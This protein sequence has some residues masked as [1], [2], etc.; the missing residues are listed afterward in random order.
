MT[1]SGSLSSE[2]AVQMIQKRFQCKNI[3]GPNFWK[4]RPKQIPTRWGNMRRKWL[5]GRSNIKGICKKVMVVCPR[6]PNSGLRKIARVK[7]RNKRVVMVYIPGIGHNLQTHSVIRVEGGRRKD[8]PG[9]NLTAIRGCFDLLPVKGRLRR[10][11]HYG[12]RRPRGKTP[13]HERHKWLTIDEDRMKY[14]LQTGIKLGATEPIPV[15]PIPTKR[16][17]TYANRPMS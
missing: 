5:E 6:K 17:Y 7:L 4:R 11:S 10:R 3:S 1:N 13:K 2:S 8:I 14:Y 9:C 15:S 12:A 16:T